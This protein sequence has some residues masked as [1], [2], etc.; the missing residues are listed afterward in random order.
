[1]TEVL[2][3]VKSVKFIKIKGRLD[4]QDFT[5]KFA[6]GLRFDSFLKILL[7]EGG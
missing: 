5:K 6:W 4:P 1:M 3:I 7:G 2:V